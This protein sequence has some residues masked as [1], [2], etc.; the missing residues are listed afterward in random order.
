MDANAPM[1]TPDCRPARLSNGQH[2]IVFRYIGRYLLLKL[3]PR[4]SSVRENGRRASACT[5][6]CE[7]NIFSTGHFSRFHLL[8]FKYVGTRYV[9]WRRSHLTVWFWA[10][11]FRLAC[12]GGVDTCASGY[13]SNPLIASYAF[14]SSAVQV[15]FKC[16]HLIFTS[17]TTRWDVISD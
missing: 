9:A 15:Q 5:Q 3:S 14:F 16:N 12:A 8:D 10:P 11:N 4:M 2:T 7:C 17:K 6:K 13:N 1:H